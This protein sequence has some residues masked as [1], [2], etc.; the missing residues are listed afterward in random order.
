MAGFDYS[1]P[2]IKKVLVRPPTKV[3]AAS[4]VRE[5][6]LGEVGMYI[7]EP[8]VFYDIQ[9]NVMDEK[10]ATRPGGFTKEEVAKYLRE[11]EKRRRIAEI[12]AEYADKLAA[13]EEGSASGV[14][15]G[16]ISV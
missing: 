15:P 9:G 3:E 12:E 14:E 6:V 4:G 8:G 5:I 7:D 2:L 10:M 1:R 11:A 16:S 13:E